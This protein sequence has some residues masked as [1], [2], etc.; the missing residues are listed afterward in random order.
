M[1][2]FSLPETTAIPETPKWWNNNIENRKWKHEKHKHTQQKYFVQSR[3][4]ICNEWFGLVDIVC[5]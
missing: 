1:F 5:R 2:S 3:N 4:S